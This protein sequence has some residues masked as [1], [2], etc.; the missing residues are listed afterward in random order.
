MHQSVKKFHQEKFPHQTEFHLKFPQVK[1]EMNTLTLFASEAGPSGVSPH[2]V[3]LYKSLSVQRSPTPE[4]QLEDLP[5][6]RSSPMF[7][8]P[9]ADGHNQYALS[10][11]HRSQRITEHVERIGRVHWG[12]RNH[13][14]IIKREEREDDEEASIAE[15]MEDEE[16]GLGQGDDK[17]E[18]EEDMPFVEPG[19]EGISIW[20]LGDGFL[21]EVAGLGDYLLTDP[22]CFLM[23]PLEGKP[24]DESD[25]TLFCAYTLKVE[26]SITNATFN[27]HCFTFPQAPL[28]T[29]KSTEK[30]VQFL[31]GFRPVRYSCC[32]LSCVCFTG[33]FETLQQCP[34]CKADRY[35][36]DGTTPCAYFEY[37][38][39]I[40]FHETCLTA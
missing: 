33:P 26:D 28:D 8:P 14:Q 24:L 15:D 40:P 12:T 31:S 32:I 27:K 23:F 25:I 34:K 18:D 6:P 9:D 4:T 29:I 11:Q 3:D 30:Q 19:Q 20:D 7:L 22:K 38:P 21:K 2:T 16:D 5:P 1:L 39:I 37:L 35:K 13:V 17:L 36:A 10:S